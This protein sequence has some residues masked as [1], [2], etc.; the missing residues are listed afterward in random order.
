MLLLRFSPLRLPVSAAS[1]WTRQRRFVL[2]HTLWSHLTPDTFLHPSL[3]C[4]HTLHL[5]FT[6]FAVLD[7]WPPSK[8][9]QVIAN[10]EFHLR[11]LPNVGE[12]KWSTC[13][14]LTRT[15]S[16]ENDLIW[17]GAVK[18][19]CCARI[20][21]HHSPLPFECVTEWKRQQVW[22]AASRDATTTTTKQTSVRYDDNI[23]YRWRTGLSSGLLFACLCRASLLTPNGCGKTLHTIEGA[24]TKGNTRTENKG[25]ICIIF[26]SKWPEFM[27]FVQMLLLFSLTND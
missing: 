8:E 25:C 14:A 3:S 16:I 10:Y 6:P 7:C 4:W 19:S 24:Q 2:T 17:D 1:L 21:P 18:Y 11:L 27:T 13:C 20:I 12:G 23:S 26:S 9:I 5:F 22:A 15:S